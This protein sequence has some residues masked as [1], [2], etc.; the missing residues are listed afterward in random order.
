MKVRSSTRATSRGSESARKLPGRLDGF[1]RRNVPPATS[2]SHKRSYSCCDPSHQTTRAGCVRR[3]I[4]VTQAFSFL[5]L[6][7]DGAV[8]AP[9]STALI[10]CLQSSL[11]HREALVVRC[12]RRAG[13]SSP[14]AIG[15]V[16]R[17]RG[18]DFAGRT[19][20]CARQLAGVRR[21][22]R[23]LPPAGPSDLVA[24]GIRLSGFPSTFETP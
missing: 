16:D 4:S 6:T 19:G 5:F 12:K 7:Y 8:T 17:M 18:A 21:R 24:L 9:E 22:C 20:G 13:H 10:A 14:A 15:L 3:A 11:R 23:S 2:S 1:N